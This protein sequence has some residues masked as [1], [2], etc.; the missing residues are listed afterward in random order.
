MTDPRVGKLA[1][2]LVEYSLEIRPGQQVVLRTTP[3]AEELNL[4]FYKEAVRAGGQ[5][6][7]MQAIP[8][9]DEAFYKLA[10]DEQL[11][12][13]SP[14]QRTIYETFD[15]MMVIDA[16]Y[17]SRELSGVDPARIARF[18]KA[19]ASLTKTYLERS[20]SGSLRWALTVYPTQAMAQDADMSLEDY[21][22]FVYRAGMLTRRRPGGLLAS[23]R[24]AAEEPDPLAQGA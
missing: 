2:L 13:I 15:A 24:R 1:R 22:D 14:L 11:E 10:S 7:V 20:A 12:F 3:N 18:G 9:Q 23:R 17:N 8:G 19:R 4:A 5:V 16:R 21:T 6:F